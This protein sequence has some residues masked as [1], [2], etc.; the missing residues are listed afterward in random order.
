MV[1]RLMDKILHDLVFI[2]YGNMVLYSTWV[3][4]KFVHQQYD[5]PQSPLQSLRPRHNTQHV[6]DHIKPLL[7]LLRPLP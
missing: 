6:Y 5:V 1:V 3:I 4:Q 2:N 7:S